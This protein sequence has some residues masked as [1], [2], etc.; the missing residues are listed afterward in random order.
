MLPRTSIRLVF[1][2]AC[3]L[4]AS[5]AAFA[6]SWAPPEQE[7]YPSEDGRWRLTVTPRP[8]GG[9]LAYFRDKVDGL[10]NAGGVP[11][12]PDHAFGRMERREGQRWVEAWSGPLV[13][14]VAPVAAL[15]SASGHA[16]TFDNWHSMGYGADVV[17]IYD[18]QG[19]VVRAMGLGDFLPPVY[20]EAL[21]RSVSSIHWSGEHAIAGDGRELVLQVV[22][23]QEDRRNREES[24]H[25][26]LR[27][28]L[29]TGTQVPPSGDAWS[30]ALIEAEKAAR[31]QREERLQRRTRFVAP[32][33]APGAG[34]TT[35][36]WH[37][38]LAE[39][40]FRLDPDWESGHPSTK[41]IVAQG[42]AD[43]RKSVRWLRDALADCDQD[44]VVM[45]ASSSQDALVAA[46][47]EAGA[48][49]RPGALQGGRIYAAVE[50]AHAEAARAALDHASP[51][52]IRL[53][54]AQS[55]PQRRE[56]LEQLAEREAQEANPESAAGD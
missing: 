5:P 38:Y 47:A 24:P 36:D 33:S 16:V 23:P 49:L 28:D 15:V 3:A 19:K 56:R 14:D 27:F 18:T 17:V 41:V 22:V 12:A 8:I 26:A 11:D 53:D 42:N 35:R 29:A 52:W 45:V 44:C 34:S 43:H 4:L 20:V 46:L 39:A 32:L 6:D 10:D 50:D 25:V 48:G 51:T 1:L 31:F 2:L 55:I 9:A 30:A 40:F 7:V 13:N 37:A 54:P 21:P